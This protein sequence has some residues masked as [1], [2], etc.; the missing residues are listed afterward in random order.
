MD[1]LIG[2][3]YGTALFEVALENNELGRMEEDI[4]TVLTA[5]KE[6][7]D[8]INIL[9]LPSILLEKKKNLIKEAFESKINQDLLGL[10]LLTLDKS[11][12]DHLVKILEYALQ[13][14][15]EEKGILTAY[16]TSASELKATE[17]EELREKLSKQTGKQIQLDCKVEK[18]LIGGMIVRIKDQIL[19]STIK[20]ELHN[21]AK[22]LYAVKISK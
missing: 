1:E 22:E 12:Q 15:Y 18:D 16:I 7:P 2:K 13:A 14:I 3:R 11:R 20:G 8:F 4:Q 10:L 17:K 5:M 9:L 6:N 19:D 21:I